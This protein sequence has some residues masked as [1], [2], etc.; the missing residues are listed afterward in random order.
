MGTQKGNAKTTVIRKI[1]GKQGPKYIPIIFKY[2]YTYIY[3]YVYCG[4]PT[5]VPI[6]IL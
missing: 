3:I 2:A 5:G 1:V 6:R 4:C